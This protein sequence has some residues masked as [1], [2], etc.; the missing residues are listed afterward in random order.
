[1]GFEIAPPSRWNRHEVM[2]WMET[3]FGGVT[4]EVQAQL[5]AKQA[6]SNALRV[7]DVD[8]AASAVTGAGAI[9]SYTLPAN[10]IT[11]DGQGLRMRCAGDRTGTTDAFILRVRF[12]ETPTSLGNSGYTAANT[13]WFIGA[14][15]IRNSSS[16]IVYT[17][18]RSKEDDGETNVRVGTLSSDIDWTATQ[19]LDVY[20]ASALGTDTITGRMFQVEFLPVAS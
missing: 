1:M 8:A 15:I 13:E 18:Y 6:T 11:A 19:T 4:S 16:A 17:R 12:G 3:L 2:A 7:L 20:Q 10:T 9:Y 14:D 5:D